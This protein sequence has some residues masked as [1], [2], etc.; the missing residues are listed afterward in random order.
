MYLLVLKCSC[1]LVGIYTS[2]EGLMR[3]KVSQWVDKKKTINCKTS[4]Q[5]N[6]KPEGE[7][8]MALSQV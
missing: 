7:A 8:G 5:K 6:R 1:V 3:W 4:K 2:R